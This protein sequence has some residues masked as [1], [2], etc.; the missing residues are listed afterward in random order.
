MTTGDTSTDEYCARLAGFEFYL[1]TDLPAP[2]TPGWV[3]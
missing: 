3:Y 1:V 2:S